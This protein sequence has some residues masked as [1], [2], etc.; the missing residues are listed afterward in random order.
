[1][2]SGLINAKIKKKKKKKEKY[3]VKIR[4]WCKVTFIDNM[5]TY[6]NDFLKE[7]TT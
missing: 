4:K 2:I 6:E 1:M 7:E 5:E 3:K